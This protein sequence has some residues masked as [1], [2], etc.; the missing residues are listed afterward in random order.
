M[1]PIPYPDLPFPEELDLHGYVDGFALTWN[2]VVIG[3]YRTLTGAARGL[4]EAR[5]A[6]ARLMS[7]NVNENWS[8]A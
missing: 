4:T 2:G 6:Y 5:Q 8:A 7:L 1:Q 3:R